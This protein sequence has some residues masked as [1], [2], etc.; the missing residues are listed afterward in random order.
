MFTQ[1]IPQTE[2]ARQQHTPIRL[3][4]GVILALVSGAMLL[5]AFA[6]YNAWPLI[7]FAFIPLILAQFRIMPAKL[8]SLA[9][10]ITVSSWVYFYFGPSFFP[11][12]IGLILALP[13]IVFIINLLAEKKVRGFHEDTHYRWFILRGVVSWVG[14]E[15][16]R[17]FIPGIATWGFVNY[18]LWSQTWL[19]Q[20][21]SIF[22]I[23]GLSLLIMFINYGLGQ[24]ALRLFD[25]RWQLDN[26][27]PISG[28]ATRKWLIGIGT[29]TLIWIGISLIQY[30]SAPE[31]P[32]TVRVAA[33]QMGETE[34]AFSHPD[35][36]ADARL[37]LL[38]GLT[39]E[40]ASQGAKIISW[41]ELALP[42]DPQQEF[43][44][45][46]QTL[47]AETAAYLVLPY[48]VF[49][50]E[51]LRNEVITLAP[52]GE[53]SEPYAKAHPVLFA[54]EP[55]GLNVGTFP[56]Y[57]TP[58]G[59]MASI[60]CYDLN[61]TDVTR[62]V[63]K[64]GAQIIAAPSSDWPGIAEK[65]NIHLVFRAIETRTSIVNAEKAFDSAIV[66][67]Y[68]H[69]LQE[70]ISTEPAQAVLVMDVPI[71]TADTFYLKTGDVLGWVA[72]AGM[73]F[74]TFF[75]GQ[76]VKR[77]KIKGNGKLV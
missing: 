17:T 12:G 24:A 41:S 55:Y 20:P 8:S 32:P 64:Q 22:S 62:K 43:T 9:P 27:P 30:T 76:L 26:V 39:R 57:D 15:I 1:T 51:G 68:G 72:L 2:S 44:A 50:E 34:V 5:A 28:S 71:G 75:S 6:P 77:E 36:D 13:L 67:P 48:G 11:E 60:I 25:K 45:E 59:T 73:V 31:T 21:V 53:F 54:G 38:A 35:M 3:A 74:F 4:I 58:I 10:A 42:F 46:L 37:A 16:I 65:Q 70:T 33:I 52:S 66:D 14:F 61:Y 56:V 69:I 18:T 49:E 47:A 29:A 7:F 23:Y 63:A 40:A 19:I